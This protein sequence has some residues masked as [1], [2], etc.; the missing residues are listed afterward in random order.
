MEINVNM[1]VPYDYFLDMFCGMYMENISYAIDFRRENCR[2]VAVMHRMRNIIRQVMDDA[3]LNVL[4]QD[5]EKYTNTKI[6]YSEMNVNCLAFV[7]TLKFFELKI[8][9]FNS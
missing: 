2:Y 1:N 4:R 8:L 5:V 3:K 7:E 9:G 6:V